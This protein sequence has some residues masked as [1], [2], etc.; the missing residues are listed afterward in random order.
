VRGEFYPN[1]AW[2]CAQST[3]AA[4]LNNVGP[5]NL[6]IKALVKGATTIL[7]TLSVYVT[8]IK[9]EPLGTIVECEALQ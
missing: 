2:H 5:G 7:R 1:G 4:K 8:V 3:R 6:K 9:P